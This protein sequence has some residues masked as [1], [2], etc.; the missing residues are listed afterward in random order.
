MMRYHIA[1]VT[2]ITYVDLIVSFSTFIEKSYSDCDPLIKFDNLDL[3][4][5]GGVYLL[6]IYYILEGNLQMQCYS[7]YSF[8]L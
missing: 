5:D 8:A 1:A 3:P 6:K 2:S 4:C 7:H